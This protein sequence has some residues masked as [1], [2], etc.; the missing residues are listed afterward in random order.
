[1]TDDVEPRL[2]QWN[3]TDIGYDPMDP[4]HV[5]ALRMYPGAEYVSVDRYRTGTMLVDRLGCQQDPRECPECG[6]VQGVSNFRY[7]VREPRT[8]G[9][10]PWEATFRP[11]SR[12]VSPAEIRENEAFMS[13]QPT[14]R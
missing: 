2:P 8:P 1:M 4:E 6:S 10:P 11:C 7:F 5:A 14:K 13:G 3:P 9:R 12:C